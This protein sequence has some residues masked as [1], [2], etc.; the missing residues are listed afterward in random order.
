MRFPSSVNGLRLGIWM[1][2]I[3]SCGALPLSI[4]AEQ[5]VVPLPS[6][7]SSFPA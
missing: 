7:C 1:L 5:V 2:G 3:T 4:I 6:P